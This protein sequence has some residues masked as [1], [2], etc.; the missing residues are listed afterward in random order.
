MHGTACS[1]FVGLGKRGYLSTYREHSL[2]QWRL[3]LKEELSLVCI[4]A[5]SRI[6]GPLKSWCENKL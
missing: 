1:V 5:K 3:P 2:L 6:A 4:K